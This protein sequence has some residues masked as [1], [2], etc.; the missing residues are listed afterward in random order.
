MNALQSADV[1]PTTQQVAAVANRRE[2]LA[3]L[4][5]KWSGLKAESGTNAPQ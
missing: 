3:K 2:A 1:T 5:A 4:I